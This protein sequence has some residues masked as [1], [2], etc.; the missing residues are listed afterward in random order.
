MLNL[1][2]NKWQELDGGY[3]IPYDAS[4]PLKK[5]ERATAK[6]ETTA[7]FS[8]LWNELHHQGDV[9]LASYYAVPHLIRI[10]KEKQ[11]YDFNAIGLVTTIEI[12]RQGDNPKLPAA[13]E[14][15]YLEAIQKDLPELIQQMMTE[16]WDTTLTAV[17][18]SALAVSKGQIEIANAIL[19]LE[20]QSTLNK[21]LENF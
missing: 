6:E 20:D 19:K 9:G 21:F 11:L 13:F 5:L 15:E 17:I 16:N 2:D 7:I 1:N 8:E 4:I 3:R 14:K 10:A 18:L 12:E